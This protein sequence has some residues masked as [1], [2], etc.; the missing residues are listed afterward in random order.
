MNYV[1][2][3]DCVIGRRFYQT[4]LVGEDGDIVYSFNENLTDSQVWEALRFANYL[5]AKG[6]A[7][8]EYSKAR[9]LRITLG[10]PE[11]KE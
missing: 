3:K 6:F 2:Q 4:I 5:Y 9:E 7:T 8:G 11:P 1:N 10:I